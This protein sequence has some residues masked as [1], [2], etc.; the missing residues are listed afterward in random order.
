MLDTLTRFKDLGGFKGRNQAMS[1][2][3]GAP[4]LDVA[5]LQ[6]YIYFQDTFIH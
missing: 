5:I 2:L 1:H 6:S 4:W 3:E